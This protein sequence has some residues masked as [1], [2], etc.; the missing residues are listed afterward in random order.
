M[1]ENIDF[2]YKD[3]KYRSS[4]VV[5]GL[6][7]AGPR[8]HLRGMGYTSEE[9]SKPFIGVINTFNEFHPGHVHL[10][11]IAKAVKEGISEAGGIPFEVNTISICDGFTLGHVG[12]CNVLPSRE[13][14]ADSV[15]VFANGNQLD[16]LVLIGGCD[17]IVPAMLM[18]ALRINIPAIM[19]TGG[20]MLPAIYQGKEY[21]TYQLKEMAGKLVK[22]ELS[23]SEYT[24]MEEIFSPGPGSCAMMG[25]A[26][27]MSIF[28]E[29]IGMTLPGCATSHA[30]L[31]SKKRIAKESGLRIV[32]L[33]QQN[34]LPRDIVTQ[35]M[36]NLG[37]QITM[38]AGG[39]TNLSL[40]IPAIAR[41]AHLKMTLE[42][43][44]TI[45]EQTPYIAKIKPSGDHTLWDLD[46]AGGVRGLMRSLESLANLDQMTV[47]GK[48]HR[49]N[50]AAL[51]ERN[52]EVIRP[53]DKAYAP[54]GSLVFLF[55][56]LA[57]EG[58][59]VKQSAVVPEMRKHSGPA[60]CFE[61]EED[62]VKAIYGSQIQHGD[63]IVIRNEGPKSGPG[64]REML[65]ATAALVGM[66]L[67]NS[68]ALI[69][70]GRF[71][72]AT[73]GPCI[74]HISPETA[75]RGPI[76]VIKDGDVI[77]I[78]IDR[79]LLQLRVSDEEIRSRLEKLPEFEPKV[80]EGY[81]ARYAKQ[82]G[83]AAEGAIL[84]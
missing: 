10:D 25:T 16:G 78:D 61:C 82:V 38:S 66:G 13:I 8:A 44:G 42:D 15:E 81:L 2:K 60:R 80:T 41:E 45:S 23:V 43:L 84:K 74:G 35:E 51:V 72:G 83:S 47:S 53:V 54:H 69:T 4:K 12:M 48:T 50:A 5:N 56:N 55:G 79:H 28:A 52:D 32:E 24:H 31:G 21:G 46:Q 1:N 14:I 57:S 36:L 26:N 63:V 62:A 20:P 11:T 59:V 64:M 17:K 6:S 39:S 30:V 58:S 40:H 71:S 34:V 27:S 67:S 9:M 68:V 22:G 33:V 76:A 7:M 19:V 49:E 29:A 70:D 77:D 3:T 65:T 73:R 75:E 37:V 18:A